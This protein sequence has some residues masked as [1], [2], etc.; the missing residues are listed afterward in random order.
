MSFSDSD[1]KKVA[2]LAKL[3]I[4]ENE[5]GDYADNISKIL[6]LVDH[7]NDVNT[8]GVKPMSHPMENLTQRLREDKVSED[9]DRDT[10]QKGAPSTESG[11]YLVPKVID[12]NT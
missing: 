8:K 10:F 1:I 3:S 2:H 11:L 6:Q 4:P 5:M 9:I 12:D 7:I